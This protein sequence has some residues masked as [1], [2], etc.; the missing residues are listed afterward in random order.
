MH[1]P[2]IE[3]CRF[4]N[5]PV[6]YVVA[7]VLIS[8]VM[9]MADYVANIQDR[10]RVN[11]FPRFQQQSNQTFEINPVSQK[12]TV[13]EQSFWEFISTDNK[14]GVIL[15]ASSIAISTSQH[16]DFA[17]LSEKLLNVLNIVNEE[18]RVSTSER[19]GLRYVDLIREK[20]DC[21]LISFVAPGLHGVPDDEI[22][23][24]NARHGWHI[25]GS[26][27]AGQLVVKATQFNDGTYFPPDMRPTS[28]KFEESIK[29]LTEEKILLLDFDHSCTESGV[30]DVDSI[31]RKMSA[32]H[33]G[34]WKAFLATVSEQAIKLWEP[35]TEE[36]VE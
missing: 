26:T 34:I 24:S 22:G 13:G 6:V 27:T 25:I 19:L 29:P 17:L 14:W 31:I 36:V 33:D 35:E 5:P 28:L 18:V 2:Y 23:L 20:A 32:L 12:V 16:R 7:E 21:D 3:F 30:F 11:G 8:P 10:L 4:K 15:T 9:K 1:N